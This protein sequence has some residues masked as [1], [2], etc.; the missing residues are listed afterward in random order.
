[1]GKLIV[2]LWLTAETLAYAAFFSRYSVLAGALIGVGSIISGLLLLR[3][4]G[5]QIRQANPADLIRAVKAG[6]LGG[7]PLTLLAA[8][9]L[10]IPG[11]LSN[12]AGWIMAVVGVGKMLRPGKRQPE[13]RDIDLGREEWTRLPDDESRR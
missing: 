6:G 13:G 7:L 9:L 5:H 4:L 8:I 1:M 11:F 3:L 12:L 2:V 10:L